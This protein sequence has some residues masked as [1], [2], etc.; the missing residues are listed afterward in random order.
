MPS[1]R[2]LSFT[3]KKVLP[4]PPGCPRTPAEPGGPSQHA[5][6]TR[7]PMG[8]ITQ[9]P[10]LC[11]RAF[12]C[13]H[14]RCCGELVPLSPPFVLSVFQHLTAA[15]LSL[16]MMNQGDS[17]SGGKSFDICSC[18]SL[19]LDLCSLHSWWPDKTRRNLNIQLC[20]RPKKTREE[21]L[22]TPSSCFW[23]T[24]ALAA[25][26]STFRPLHIFMPGCCCTMPL[27]WS[28]SA[29]SALLKGVCVSLVTRARA[30]LYKSDLH[31][32]HKDGFYLTG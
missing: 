24:L 29:L 20:W 27:N 22:L 31:Q 6:V 14:P 17:H 21:L 19:N 30:H 25:P 13:A 12:S 5:S 4:S 16:Q 23:G 2:F 3:L 7:F 26:R 10:P 11:N 32:R 9:S 1:P 28:I 18:H 8:C 15:R